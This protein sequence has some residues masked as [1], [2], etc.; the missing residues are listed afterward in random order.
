MPRQT[1]SHKTGTRLKRRLLM[2]AVYGVESIFVNLTKQERGVYSIRPLLTKF[3]DLSEL[4]TKSWIST[5]NAIPS[6]NSLHQ[7][8]ST[9]TFKG[10]F[11]IMCD[12]NLRISRVS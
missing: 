4:L 5:E 3:S 2:Q 9:Q 8:S 10:P 6:R 1:A 11:P 12:K 7:E